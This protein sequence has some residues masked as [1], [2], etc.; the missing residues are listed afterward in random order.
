[1]KVRRILTFVLVIVLLVG[2]ASFKGLFSASPQAGSVKVSPEQFNKIIKE[3][4]LV[5]FDFSATWCGPCKKLKPVIEEIAKEQKGKILVQN[6]DTDQSAELANQMSINAIPLVILY[7]DQKAVWTLE[8]YSDKAGIM[9]E[10]GK[11]LK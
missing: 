7:K 2:F 10:I 6:I 4:R 3:N 9:A 1:M 5:L 11:Y 8:G